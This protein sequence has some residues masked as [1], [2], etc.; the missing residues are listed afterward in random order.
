MTGTYTDLSRNLPKTCWSTSG[1]LSKV[2]KPVT[3]RVSSPFNN[4]SQLHG[5]CGT[6]HGVY[7]FHL[8]NCC[9][10]FVTEPPKGLVTL[11]SHEVRPRLITWLTP[12]PRS[13]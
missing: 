9:S 8:D 3:L 7:V 1:L 2:F 6:F 4:R 5:T 10:G 12:R 11:T 13:G